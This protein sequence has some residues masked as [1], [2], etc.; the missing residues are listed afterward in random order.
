MGFTEN[1]KLRAYLSEWLDPIE[2]DFYLTGT[3]GDKGTCHPTKDIFTAKRRFD[4]FLDEFPKADFKYFYACEPHRTKFLHIHSLLKLETLVMPSDE[5]IWKVW[6]E[7]LGRC[8]VSVYE[9][10]RGVR[11]YLTKYV[12]KDLFDYQ[13]KF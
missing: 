6:F 11:Y 7:K 5:D 2:W 8:T 10:D 1:L 9:K 3:F 13:V 12:T 4:R